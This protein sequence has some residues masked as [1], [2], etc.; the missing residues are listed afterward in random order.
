MHQCVYRKLLRL[1]NKLPNMLRHESARCT[2]LCSEG[3]TSH[4]YGSEKE[5]QEASDDE[6]RSEA[7][8]RRQEDEK[9]VVSAPATPVAGWKTV[10]GPDDGLSYSF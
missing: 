7:E 3:V 8:S 2:L 5:S 1:Q 6:G 9:E 10:S 4:A